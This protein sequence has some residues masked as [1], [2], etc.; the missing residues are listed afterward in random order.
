M[1]QICT[2]MGEE[3]TVLFNDITCISNFTLQYCM[4]TMDTT[5]RK[6][7]LRLEI[8]LKNVENDHKRHLLRDTVQF[9]N[10]NFWPLACSQ[11]MKNPVKHGSTFLCSKKLSRWV[12][13]CLLAHCCSWELKTLFRTFFLKSS[14]HR[15]HHNNSHC[16]LLLKLEK[17]C[18]FSKSFTRRPMAH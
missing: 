9:I 18:N 6:G 15:H 7:F 12:V 11:K 4:A 1:Y 13:T 10:A 8:E 2:D 16:T 17:Q 14:A 3:N 5:I